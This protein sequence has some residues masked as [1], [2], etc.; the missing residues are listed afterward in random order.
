M[1]S[2]LSALCLAAMFAPSDLH[3]QQ[4]KEKQ[5]VLTIRK[6]ENFDITGDGTGNPKYRGTFKSQLVYANGGI[7]TNEQ[8]TNAAE[9][10]VIR[11]IS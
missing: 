11:I 10:R 8:V 2:F 7:T 5:T 9:V 1:R 6:T 3:A 4:T